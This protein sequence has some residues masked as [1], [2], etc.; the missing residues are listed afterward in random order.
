MNEF[1][2]RRTWGPTPNYPLVEAYE[3]PSKKFVAIAGPCSVE[4]P[5]MIHNLA[6]QVAF[7]GATHLR[8][9]VFRAGTYP[10]KEFGYRPESLLN[11]FYTAAQLNGLE[12][13]IEVLDYDEHALDMVNKYCTAFQVG[14]RQMQ[15][16]T[17][18]RILG[19]YRKPVFLKRNP[20][21]TLD[22]W[23]GAA[24][25]LLKNGVKEIYLIERGSSSFVTHVRWDLSISMIP[26][27]AALSKI[28]VIIDGSHGTGRRDLVEPMILAGVAAGAAGLLCEVHSSP[29]NSL[30]DP[31][32][33]VTPEK[34][35]S[36]MV[37]AKQIK[38][39]IKWS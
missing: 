36:I 4:N 3:P 5:E 30:S 29:A 38:E 19:A 13:I 27:I 26:A 39:V 23:L 20:G 18:L 14:A 21:A 34:F 15:N 37:K 10:G 7:A 28:P 6:A 12:N 9:G 31:D 22:E 35:N 11:S 24:E 25:H 32:Q 16:Y 17:L 33:A 1:A 8:G 2:K